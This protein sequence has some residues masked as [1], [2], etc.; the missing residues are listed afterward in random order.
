MED[1]SPPA[2]SPASSA[3]HA[4][5]TGKCRDTGSTPGGLKQR[6]SAGAP[7]LRR[8]Y[9]VEIT[10]SAGE[11]SDI[12][13]RIHRAPHVA[14][15]ADQGFRLDGAILDVVSDLLVELAREEEQEP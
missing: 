6:R 11:G 7:A 3:R 4:S 9:V 13:A 5:S 12:T 15:L 1:G 14:A 8:S 2:G 10:S